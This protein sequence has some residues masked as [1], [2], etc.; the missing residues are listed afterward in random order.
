MIPSG[1]ALPS[2]LGP[3]IPVGELFG[4]A[5]VVAVLAVVVGLLVLVAGLIVDARTG[6]SRRRIAVT[7]N[8]GGHPA[9]AAQHAA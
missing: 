6:R 8:G 7:A 9:G 1:A 5:V 2:A 4:P 3:G